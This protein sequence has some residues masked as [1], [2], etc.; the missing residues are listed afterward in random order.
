MRTLMLPRPIPISTTP[1][2]RCGAPPWPGGTPTAPISGPARA[3][4]WRAIVRRPRSSPP[5]DTT[6]RLEPSGAGASADDQTPAQSLPTFSGP[7]AWDLVDPPGWVRKDGAVGEGVRFEDAFPDL[8]RLAYR[9]SFRV[10]G[11]RGD[12][13]DVAQEALARAHLRWIRLWD[14][15]EGWVVTVATNLAIDRTRRRRRVVPLVNEPLALVDV[16]Q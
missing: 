7:G 9:V 14:R 12:A 6:S 5:S 8:Y 3:S 2:V 1:P 13:E 11:D 16:Y 10:L 15:P 4:G